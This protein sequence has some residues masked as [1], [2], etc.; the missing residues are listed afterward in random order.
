M[1]TDSF[2]LYRGLSVSETI[3]MRGGSGENRT[4]RTGLLPLLTRGGHYDHAFSGFYSPIVV[5]NILRDL[6][7][8][9]GQ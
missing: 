8:V 4:K 7:M 9:V 1:R 3:D 6:L 2:I 5:A